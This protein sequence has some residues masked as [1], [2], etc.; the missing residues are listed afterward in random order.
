[1]A[2]EA[3][4]SA[5]HTL[6]NSAPYGR[7]SGETIAYTR[8]HTAIVIRV[9]P[10]DGLTLPTA[11]HLRLA[12]PPKIAPTETGDKHMA[13]PTVTQTEQIRDAITDELAAWEFDDNQAAELAITLTGR[14]LAILRDELPRQGTAQAMNAGMSKREQAKHKVNNLLHLALTDY[15][16][17]DRQVIDFIMGKEAEGQPV[18]KFAE[19]WV[20][21]WK[22]KNSQP[23][24]PMDI[25]HNWPGKSV[26]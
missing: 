25:V 13:L 12:Q 15:T 2:S 20:T 14:V 6:K 5:G 3:E 17:T 22:G 9:T 23:P 18:E 8:L 26:V 11:H 1:M 7:D 4:T 10:Y 24:S 19:W 21:F 16:K